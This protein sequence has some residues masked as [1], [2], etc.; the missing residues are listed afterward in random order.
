[1]AV[2]ADIFQKIGMY[3]QY[4]FV[5]YA[6][7]VGIFIAL[8]SSL[9]G[10]T[11]VLKK[12]SYIGD[13]L[14]H[15]AF[16]ALAVATVLSFSN[17]MYFVLAV[18]IVFAVLLLCKRPS[19]IVKADA[20]VGMISVGSLAFG[21][22]FLNLFAPPTNPET[23]VRLYSVQLQ[24][25]LLQKAKLY[26]LLSFLYLSLFSMQFFTTEFLQLLLMKVFQGRVEST[27]G[28]TI[29]SWL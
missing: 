27:P 25:L 9:L 7:I 29:F 5:V 28:Y 11:L 18:T 13:G 8:C 21:Y 24:S 22:L 17:N 26:F 19:S 6:L 23:Y 16:G 20:A 12:F 10:V 1:M 15:S 14:S 2:I 3:F 4:S